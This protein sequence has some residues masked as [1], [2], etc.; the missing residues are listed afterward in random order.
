MKIEI[1]L[2]DGFAVELSQSKAK[3]IIKIVKK[4]S[5][6]LG[7]DF[8]QVEEKNIAAAIAKIKRARTSSST[9]AQYALSSTKKTA[10]AKKPASVKK[11]PSFSGTTSTG[12]KKP[13]VK[14]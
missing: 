2:P 9:I 1:E 10:A 11:S 8:I 3:L 14:Y 12:P 13:D 7:S 5:K 4:K 6:S